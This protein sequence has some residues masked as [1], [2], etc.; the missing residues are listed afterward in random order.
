[1]LFFLF[2]DHNNNR[3]KIAD[4]RSID[5]KKLAVNCSPKWHFAC[6]H[7]SCYN[8]WFKCFWCLHVNLQ[9]SC[10]HGSDIDWHFS[11]FHL[12]LL[13]M[14][15]SLTLQL[16]IQQL[17]ACSYTLTPP[18]LAGLKLPFVS[19]DYTSTDLICSLLSALQLTLILF[20]CFSCNSK[21]IFHMQTINI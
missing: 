14:N 15:L 20:Q 6:F 21:T 11:C 17:P 1:M 2:I 8:W 9:F 18:C 12:S 5:S 3:K 19:R 10:F 4:C 13:E 7:N 16:L